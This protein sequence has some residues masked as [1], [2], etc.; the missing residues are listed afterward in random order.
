MIKKRRFVVLMAAVLTIVFGSLY[1]V[2]CKQLVKQY[3]QT[4]YVVQ[5]G[6]FS[7]QENADEMVAKLQTNGHT[8]Y[9]YNKDGLIYVLSCLS[10]DEQAITNEMQSLSSQQISNVKRDYTYTG[11]AP[12]SVDTMLAFLGGNG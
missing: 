6:A 9:T 2:A 4:F 7:T 12:L 1:V 10:T 8:P 3:N 5:V 11:S